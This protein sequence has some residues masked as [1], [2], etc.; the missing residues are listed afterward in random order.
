MDNNKKSITLSIIGKPN[1]GKSTLLNNLIGQKISITTPKVQTTRTIITG[2][3]T[4][5]DTQIII[6]DTPGIFEPKKILE[7]EMVRCA[8]SSIHSVD[9]VAL[10]LDSTKKIDEHTKKIF[11]QLKNFKLPLIV[12]INKIEIVSRGTIEEL[13]NQISDIIDCNEIF[14]ISAIKGE[15]IEGLKN[16]LI[17]NALPNHWLYDEDDVTNSSSRFIASEMTREQ[18]FLHLDQEL[19]YNL[20]IQTEKWE[21]KIYKDGTKSIS[22]NQVI[23]VSRDTY[24]KII[25]GHNGS[26]IKLIGTLARKELEKFFNCKINLFLFVKVRDLWYKFNDN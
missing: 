24:K 25:I 11:A 12:I 17:K 7:K 8:W 18:L 15:G 21:E 20:S 3:V 4:F 10:I 1:A 23:V 2:I 5:G 26:K 16:Y 19:P 6:S 22:I 14:E 9:L 13:R